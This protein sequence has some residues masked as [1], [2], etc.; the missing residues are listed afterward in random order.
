MRIIEDFGE[1]SPVE[2]VLPVTQ[3]LPIVFNS[4]HSGNHYPVSFLESSRLDSQTIRR[5]ED[6][7]VDFLFLDVV[8][9]GAPLI[10]ANFPRSF[11]DVNREPFELDPKMFNGHLPEYTNS[12][13]LK[14][15]GGLGTIARTVGGSQEIYESRLD[16]HEGLDRIE[17][18]YIPYHQLVQNTLLRI[19]N[20]FG[21]A[22][23]V[24][25][26]SMP[27]M[28][29]ERNMRFRPD[30]VLGDRYGASCSP[31]LV[32]SA[33]SILRSMGY[34]VVR[35]MPFAGGFITSHYGQPLHGFHAFQLEINRGIYLDEV[36]ICLTENALQLKSDLA[37]F[38][39]Q[40][41]RVVES[42][43]HAGL[44]AAE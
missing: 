36:N 9:H 39:I 27:S 41:A 42:D 22:I 7:F 37:E 19:Q 6:A 25:C 38:A 1:I 3:T 17:Q 28:L 11:L 34:T 43:F 24:D 26:H 10:R 15:A 30:F 20:Q 8:F 2:A 44:I 13:S 12:R 21:N 14:V 23:L 16:V 40:F 33:E 35:N 32:S 18:L 4:P 29:K 5:S 31:A